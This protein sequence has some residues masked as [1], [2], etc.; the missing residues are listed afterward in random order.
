MPA[1]RIGHLGRP[2]WL[3]IVV[4]RLY[5]SFWLA[6]LFG[7]FDCRFLFTIC[8]MFRLVVLVDLF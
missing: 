5:W 7:S 8:M 2:F 1:F 6:V 3:D 4:S